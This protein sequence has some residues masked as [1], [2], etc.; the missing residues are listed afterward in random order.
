M[1]LV[2]TVSIVDVF[3]CPFTTSESDCI[4]TGLVKV[5]SLCLI[6]AEN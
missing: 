4:T 1:S 5:V 3:N 2:K 6:E